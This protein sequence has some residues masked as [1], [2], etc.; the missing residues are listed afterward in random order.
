MKN[1]ALFL[2]LAMCSWGMLNAQVDTEVRIYHKLDSQPFNFTSTAQNNLGQMFKVTRLQYYMCEFTI[3]YD[4]GQE[5]IVSPDT[6]ALISTADGE[7]STVL[8]GNLN[9]TNV[10]G[11]K[12]HIGVPEPVNNDDPLLF[13]ST[14]PLA[15]Q[16]PSMHWGW[17]AGYRFL[18]YEGTG[19]ANF[20]QTFQLHALGNDNYFETSVVSVAQSIGGKLIVALDADYTR[21]VENIDVSIGT[22]AHGVDGDDLTALTNFRDYV[23]SQSSQISSSI[24]VE[25][26]VSFRWDVYPIPMVGNTLN[27]AINSNQ[28][29]DEVIVRNILGERGFQSNWNKGRELSLEINQSGMYFISLL[30]NSNIIATKKL[31]KQ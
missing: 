22:I 29:V 27:I 20:A 3:V 1:K 5:L 11:V 12:F 19:G 31:I 28:S 24:A 8:L 10:E 17:A 30:E 6:V 13:P 15:P 18:V 16:S 14:H 26:L 21:G 9:I 25:P 23:F 4:G 7:Y 2:L